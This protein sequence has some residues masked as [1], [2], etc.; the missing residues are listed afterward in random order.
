MGTVPSKSLFCAGL[1]S[2]Y[3]AACEEGPGVFSHL[4][5]LCT[6]VLVVAT[7]PFSLFFVVKVVQVRVFFDIK[8]VLI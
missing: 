1:K 7:L 4:L 5:T 6:L 3:E 8:D 2:H